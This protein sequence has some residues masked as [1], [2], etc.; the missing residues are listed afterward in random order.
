VSPL[1][2]LSTVTAVAEEVKC[3]F[4]CI[5]KTFLEETTEPTFF[6]KRSMAVSPYNE[7]MHITTNDNYK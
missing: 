7:I 6:Y 3:P 1:I 2:A 5:D 4:S